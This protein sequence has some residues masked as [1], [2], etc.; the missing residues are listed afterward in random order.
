MTYQMW[1]RRSPL[2]SRSKPMYLYIN[3]QGGSVISGL[4]LHDCMNHVKSKVVTIRLG[5]AASMASFIFGARAKGK[6]LALQNN[7]IIS[8]QPICGAQGQAEEMKAEAA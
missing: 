3:W 1:I 4:V 6:R 2:F 7:R 5:L 8:H